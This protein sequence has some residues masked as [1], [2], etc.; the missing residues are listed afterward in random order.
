MAIETAPNPID[1]NKQGLIGKGVNRID[2]PLKV[3]G[4]AKYSYEH[5]LEAKTAYGFLVGATIAKGKIRKINTTQAEKAPGVLLVLTHLNAPVQGDYGPAIPENT[6]MK[7]PKPFLDR[8]EIRYYGEPVA[9]VVAETFEAARNAAALVKVDYDE[10]PSGRFSLAKFQDQAYKPSS[11]EPGVAADTQQ[12]DFEDAFRTAPVQV[13]AT[14]TTPYQHHHAMEL[15]ASLATWSGDKLTIYSAHQLPASCCITLAKTLKVPK[16]NIRLLC[17]YIGGGFGGKL[18]TEADAILSAL[19][20]RMLGRPVKTSFTRQ[21]TFANVPHRG[22]GIQRVRLGASPEGKLIAFGHEC[23]LQTATFDECIEQAATFSRSLYAAPHRLTRHRGVALDLPPAGD[24]RAPGEAIGMLAVEQ[25][26][27][28]LA[29]QLNID[30]VELRVINEPQIDPER[31]VPF[32]TRAMVPCLR[33]GARRFG[34]ENRPQKPGE[35]RDGE[36]FIG[37]GMAA[38]IRANYLAESEARVVMDGSGKLRVEM[39]MT[40]IGTGTYTIMA[41]IAAETMGLPMSEVEV[42]M[43]DSDFPPTPGSGGSFGANSTG[44]ALY[45]ACMEMRKQLAEAAVQQAESPLSGLMAEAATFEN[46]SVIIQGKSDRYKS[47][48]SRLPQQ[49]LTANGS[50]TPLKTYEDYSQAAYGAHF[51]EVGVHAATGEIRLHRML[52]VF[53]AGRILNEKTAN[54]QA[55]GGMIWGVGGALLEGS[56]VD[57]RY[58]H[59]INQD[60]AGYHIAAHADVPNIQAIFLPEVDDKTGPLKIK[61]IGELSICGS[62]AAVANAVYNACGVRVRD[63]PITLDKIIEHLPEAF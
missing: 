47:I 31:Q 12:G 55:I 39:A 18:Y 57:Q 51:V 21:Q 34:W 32:S 46:G 56:V 52:G 49:K 3:T 63:Y 48:V 28:E 38:S 62:G 44:S 45:Y 25:A 29:C 2:G 43:G 53:T 26:M 30:P 9:F 4:Q 35:K 36:W 50:I 27:D 13:D 59:F 1:E 10:D 11:V 7:R 41:Q 42:E 58:G 20:A 8:T 14:Y 17:K 6:A 22:E 19:A 5:Q 16:E 33:E 23:W 15:H 61:G 40:D 54:S 24:M 60:L 37:Y